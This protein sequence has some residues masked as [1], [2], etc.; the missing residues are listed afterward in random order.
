MTGRYSEGAGLRQLQG[1]MAVC[2]CTDWEKR[3]Y[4]GRLAP[5]EPHSVPCTYVT[6]GKAFNFS[7]TFCNL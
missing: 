5:W 4:L 7:R 2:P 1:H 3:I 6:L